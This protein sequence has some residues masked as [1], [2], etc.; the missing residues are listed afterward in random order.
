MA[1]LKRGD[2]AP[3]FKLQ[4]Q[5]GNTVGLDGFKGRT[6]LLYFYVKADTPGCT[7]QACSVRDT[8]ADLKQLDLPAVG[9][10]PDPVA[11]QK[12]FDVKYKLGFPL[13]SDTGH[14]VADAFGA[15]DS[16]ANRITRSSFLIDDQGL[17]VEAWYDVKP[18]DTVPKAKEAARVAAEKKPAQAGARKE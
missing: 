9:I 1:K 14:K 7:T 8:A 13:L 16:N 15:W 17:I 12:A 6:L 2:K 3:D 4:D 18:E 5:N 11:D 10:S